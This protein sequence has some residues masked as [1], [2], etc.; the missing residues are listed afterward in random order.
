MSADKRLQEWPALRERCLQG[1]QA[2]WH[3]FDHW[4]R[5]K[6]GATLRRVLGRHADADDLVQGVLIRLWTNDLRCF[7]CLDSRRCPIN[8][9]VT[10]GVRSGWLA[11]E[12]LHLPGEP[13]GVGARG[14]G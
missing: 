5:P 14:R 3:E 13:A 8:F 2:A 10:L 12:L 7:R 11:G 1:D 9:L 6:L 4:V